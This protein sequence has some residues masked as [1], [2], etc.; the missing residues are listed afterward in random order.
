MMVRSDVENGW[1]MEPESGIKLD[2]YSV[3]SVARFD[4]HEIQ[5]DNQL[6]CN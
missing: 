2:E 5:G 6:T 1:Q 4:H 3:R